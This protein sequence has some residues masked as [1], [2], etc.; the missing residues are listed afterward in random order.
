M[1]VGGSLEKLIP[2]LALNFWARFFPGGIPRK[3]LW[4][5]P[6]FKRFLLNFFPKINSPHI[7]TKHGI[8]FYFILSNFPLS[9]KGSS[10]NGPWSPNKI[11]TFDIYQGNSSLIGGSR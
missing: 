5:K 10:F 2:G 11:Y 7:G 3:E 9:N 8:G 6:N 4:P 1:G